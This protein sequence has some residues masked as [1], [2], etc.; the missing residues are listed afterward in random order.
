MKTAYK[1]S[2]KIFEQ[3]S[4]KTQPGL[5][6]QLK[7]IEPGEL[8]A[9]RG[10]HDH[11]EK[12]LDT[13]K[14]PYELISMEQVPEHNG[15]RV[16]FLNCAEYA[17]APKKEETL[18][19]LV[20]EG[21]RVVSTDWS[22]GLVG[23][24]FPGKF[25]KTAKTTDDVV[26]IECN[27]DIAL[28]FIG[29]NYAQCKPQWWLEGSS[30]IYS[31][32]DGVVPIITS[33]EM[34]TKYGQPYVASGFAAGRGEVFHFISHLELQRT[35]QKGKAS[36]G[37]ETFLEKLGAERTDDMEDAQF[38][39]L[40]AAYST[41]NT[42]AHLCVNVPILNIGMNSMTTKKSASAATKKSVSLA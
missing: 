30:D 20:Q 21:G 36:G 29:L 33:E 6:A 4:M 19:T 31:I 42:L 40:E 27:T 13:L 8:V 3:V 14:V 35:K 41:L 24:M 11:I 32:T 1:S 17:P 12:L 39:E 22:V 23:R 26:E 2:G 7:S 38:A 25:A 28:K 10:Q 15:G 9:V 18:R 16:F 5:Y 37:L 34:K